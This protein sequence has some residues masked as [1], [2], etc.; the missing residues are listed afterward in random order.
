MN[1]KS[2]LIAGF[3]ASVL[4]HVLILL[5]VACVW[6]ANH[7]TLV[8][9]LQ[10]GESS[11]ALTLVSTPEPVEAKPA[12]DSPLQAVYTEPAPDETEA[13]IAETEQDPDTESSPE[14]SDSVENQRPPATSSDADMLTK[15]VLGDARPE[16]EIRP[17]YPLGSRMRGEQGAVTLDVTVAPAGT[18]RHIDVIRSSGY[19]ALDQAALRAMERARFVPARQEAVPIESHATL[20]FRFQLTD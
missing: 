19:H 15:G 9:A 5:C 3:T 6:P 2:D 11:L 7:T 12:R 13:V 1:R 10:T 20:V 8:P 16:S 18:A 17:Y 4:L 14:H